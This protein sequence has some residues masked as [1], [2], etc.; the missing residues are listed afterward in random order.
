MSGAEAVEASAPWA[1]LNR[2]FQC[3]ASWL[4][5][6][7]SMTLP[8]RNSPAPNWLCRMKITEPALFEF[9]RNQLALPVISGMTKA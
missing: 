5:M 6:G 9:L 4:W 1:P 7:P 3:G 8:P 2:R